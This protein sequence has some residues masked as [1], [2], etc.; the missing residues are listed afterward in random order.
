MGQS[1]EGIVVFARDF[2]FAVE[3][4][5]ELVDPRAVRVRV[6]AEC[7]VDVLTVTR[8]SEDSAHGVASTDETLVALGL[9]YWGSPPR[10]VEGP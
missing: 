7:D 9:E 1:R 2:L 5:I 6:T 10:C 4:G 3:A 8:T